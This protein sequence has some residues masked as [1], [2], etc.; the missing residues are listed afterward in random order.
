MMTNQPTATRIADL[1]RVIQPFT[2]FYRES[3]YTR[4]VSEPDVCDFAIGNPHEL[5]LPEY[6]SA[7]Q[8]NAQPQN[9]DW[10]A[11][12]TSEPASQQTVAATLREWRDMDFD[13]ADICMTNGG[14]AAISL[15]LYSV[16]DPGDEVI[17][18]TPP[19]FFYELLITQAQGVPVRVPINSDTFDLDL[20]AIAAAITP[21]TRAII[22]N[23]PNNP[24]GKIYGPNTLEK[25]A[26][27]LSEA[28]QRNGRTLYLLSDEAYSRIIYDN[29]PFYSPTT[30][31]PYSFLLYT[32]GKT[33][34]APG[35]RIGYIALP[36]TM[37][38]VDRI[39]LREGIF[40]SQLA[41]SFA[42]P[43]ALLQHA[44][45]DLEKQSIDI[46]HLQTKRNRLVETLR[47][48]GYDVHLPQGTFYLLP[49][50]PL[51]DD[52]TFTE[53]LAQNKIL[54]L[55]GEVVELPGFFR[56]SLTAADAMIDRSL[57]G[58]EIAFKQ[59]LVK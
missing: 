6:V 12:K 32:Y 49:R 33:L 16:V 29:Q 13:P 31:Y 2:R 35:Q 36:P 34:L 48:I 38:E 45:P 50:S 44:L 40:V 58:F 17:F 30:Y 11:Y 56:L 23:S 46:E 1:N 55:P 26:T 54:A 19:W 41:Q 25:L 14:F 8:Q 51:A 15:A 53:I 10:F 18:I 28:G 57:A 20:D 43:N 27:I 47:G 5:P 42:F 37:P 21:R 9:K 7:L 24:T 59:A 39:A 4:L 22:I 52:W 3:S